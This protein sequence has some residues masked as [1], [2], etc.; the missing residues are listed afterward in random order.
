MPRTMHAL[1]AIAPA[2]CLRPIADWFPYAEAYWYPIPGHPG[3]GCYGTGYDHN[4]GIQ[5]NLKYVGAMAALAV[6]GP[7]AGLSEDLAAR[8][9][10]RA[11]AALRFDLRTHLTGD[12]AR[13]DGRQWGHGWITGLGIERAMFGVYLLEPHLSDEDRARLREVLTSEADWLLTEY[14]VVADPWGTSGK[15]KPESNMWNGAILWRAAS[16]YPDHPHTVAWRE[17]AHLFFLNAVSVPEDAQDDRPIAGKPLCEWHV[18]ANFFPHYA[19]DH[20]GYTNVGYS[21]IT[22][23]NAAMLHYDLASRGYERPASLYHHHAELW[24]AVRRTIFSDGRLARIGGDSRVRYAYCQE[25]LLPT[26]IYAVDVLGDGE[27]AVLVEGMLEMIRGEMAYGGDGSYYARRLAPLAEDNP[28][29]HSRLESDR[30]AVLAQAATYLTH[31]AEAGA[32][33]GAGETPAPTRASYEAS[34]AGGWA[35]PEYGA[36]LHRSPTRLASFAWRAHGLAQGM[37]QPPDDGHLA[38]WHQNLAGVVRFQGDGGVIPGGQTTHRRLERHEIRTYEGGFLTYGA[39]TEGLA[40]AFDEGWKGEQPALHQIV[41]CALPD[42]NTVVGLELCRVGAHRAYLVECKGLH[43]N[44]PND[45]YNGFRRTLATAQGEVLLASPAPE[46]G[47]TSLGG[48]WANHEG[49]VGVVGVYGAEELVVSRARGRRGGKYASLYVEEICWPARVTRGAHSVDAGATVLDV[50]W[51][52]LST[53]DAAATARCAEGAEALPLHP[54]HPGVRGVRIAGQDGRT[55]L[56]LAN[57]SA[58]PAAYP[59]E[60]VLGSARRGRDLTSGALLTLEM[61]DVALAGGAA[62]ALVLDEG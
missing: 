26:L 43:L 23:S 3:L 29:Y 4:W 60:G 54:A 45:L 1:S 51:A 6:L 20:H 15:N 59:V 13:L 12:L 62:R 8:A 27:A 5:T 28:Y 7:A 56:V 9:L 31:L 49:R 32:L 18:G 50:G 24:D 44:L 10:E 21:V 52:V 53:V 37:C 57:L 41:F 61:G 14:E 19:L 48:R 42:G 11:L 17:K 58:E 47:V 25:Y 35:E 2:D 34:V 30:A 40:L 36:V 55:Y 22:L 38:E 16:M 39:V 33:A 46:D